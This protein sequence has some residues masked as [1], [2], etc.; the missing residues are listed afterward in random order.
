MYPRTWTG[1][2]GI[3]SGAEWGTAKRNGYGG[4]THSKPQPITEEEG[5]MDYVL[6][7]A[8]YKQGWIDWNGIK[9]GT[10]GG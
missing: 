10:K 1:V 9:V 5:E 3:G 8:Y 6:E 7:K 2:T 4:I